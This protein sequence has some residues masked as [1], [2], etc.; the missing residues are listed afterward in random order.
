MS[1]EMSAR[2]LDEALLAR[3]LG[4][5]R[6]SSLSGPAYLGLA[7]AIKLLIVDGRLPVG[8][9]YPS[10]RALADAIRVSRTTVTAAYA[11]LREDGYLNARRG[12]R[13]TTALPHAASTAGP[14]PAARATS[15]TLSLADAAPSAPP[16]ATLEAFTRAAQRVAPYLHDIGIEL[17]GIPELRHA[18]AER[19]CARGLPTDPDEIM[20]TS[21]ALNAINL[22]LA[23]YAQPGDRVLV[24]QP[25]YHGA[26]SAITASGA[27]PV[28]VS[29]TDAGWELDAVQA[30]MRQ[31]APTL[32][33]LIVDNHNPT[34]LSLPAAGRER[35]ARIIAETRTRTIVDETVCD[36]WLD[37]PLPP[38][39]AAYLDSR[40][41]LLITIG[42]M[43]KSF[44]GGLRVGW[45]RA[46]R[47]TLA[48][49]AAVRPTIDLGTAIVEQLA[50]ADLLRQADEVLPAR[51]ELLRTRRELA[52]SLLQEQLP[53]WTAGPCH[54]GLSLWMRLPAPMS[55]A[56]SAAA[57]RMGLV[58]PA[59]PRFGVDGSL[60]RFIRV[61]YTQPEDRLRESITVLAGAWRS[62][63]GVGTPDAH[64]VVV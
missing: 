21:G 38:P 33:Y 49:I 25:T 59:G 10:E 13:S 53:E 44:W 30:A 32:A 50:S 52:S 62:V 8:A 1:I 39:L 63:T 43:S 4:N 58:I 37:E 42:S 64:A 28:P 26:I 31:L 41:D 55:S 20:V 48:A 35:L 14:I 47:S 57:A 19:Y 36:V 12:A 27:R 3:E 15:G 11:Q 2:S 6:T 24:E 54:G 23:T 40:R 17:T 60:E 51:R 5:W 34:G 16:A 7:D 9:R 18:I 56:L 22:V 29:M 61:P 46:E 45:I